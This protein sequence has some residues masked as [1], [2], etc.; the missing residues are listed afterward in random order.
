MLRQVRNAHEQVHNIRTQLL[1]IA[2]Q[3]VGDFAK[4]TGAK[5]AKFGLKVYSTATQVAAKVAG[6]IPEIG[7]GVGK[8][9]SGVSKAAGVVSDKIHANLG[10]KLEKGMN[11]M[12]KAQKVMGFI[13]TRRE[14]S[15]DEDLD[16]LG[17]DIDS[18]GYY[19]ERR[20]EFYSDVDVRDTYDHYTEWE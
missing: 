6:F 3:K 9:L 8:V 10:S 15:L 12:N 17:R 1:S 2:A 19:L 5:I 20:E 4:T 14:L 16:L 7:T 18:D 13:P 11:V